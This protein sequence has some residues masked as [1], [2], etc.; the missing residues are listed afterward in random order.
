MHE[1]PHKYH[2]LLNEILSSSE[3]S[4]DESQIWRDI[5][6]TYRKH[7]Q[8]QDENGALMKSLF[9]VLRVY[10]IF[11]RELGYCQGACGRVPSCAAV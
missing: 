2:R 5:V 3:P 6:R 1:N 10:S 7:A 9:N 11:D 4:A 8:F